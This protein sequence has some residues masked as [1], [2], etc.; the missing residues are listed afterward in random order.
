MKLGRGLR[1]SLSA[2][3]VVGAPV[4]MAGCGSSPSA[5][6]TTTTTSTSTTT[7][8]TTP[9]LNL[10]VLAPA[11]VPPLVNECRQKLTY[12]ADG[13]ASPL[14]CT[15]GGL[16]V[17]AWRFYASVG[18][19]VMSLGRGAALHRIYSSMCTDN[20][21]DHATGPE[22]QAAATLASEYYGWGVVPQVSTFEVGISCPH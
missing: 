9:N 21:V 11:S 1:V 16:N 6:P 12:S 13:N 10:A 17:L 20:S 4:L 22:E 15:S 7:T 8:T 5:A 18:T 2:L 19:A 3:A 14:T